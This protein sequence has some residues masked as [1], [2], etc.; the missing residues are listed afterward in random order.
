VSTQAGS[1]TVVGTGIKA[2]AH[3]TAEGMEAIRR[4]DKVLYGTADPLTKDWILRNA[5]SA[6]S[7]D[8]FYIEGGPRMVAYRQMIEEIVDHVR[9]GF[10]VCVSF[11]GHPGAFV[12]VSHESIRLLRADGYRT[13]MLP[14]VSTQDVLFCDLAFDPGQSGCQTFEATDFLLRGYQ[15]DVTSPLVLWQPS[16][17]GDF[18]FWPDTAHTKNLDVL[19][20]VLE[21]FYGRDHD[22]IAYQ[23]PLLVVTKPVITRMIIGE[24]PELVDVGLATL[25]VPSRRPSPSNG[26]GDSGPDSRGLAPPF[27]S[28]GFKTSEGPGSQKWR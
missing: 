10:K 23:A 17:I 9:G 18:R 19:A 13:R 27:D 11:E 7:L 1:L 16:C 20:E 24:L 6:A 25:Y 12:Y 8:R 3:M 28:Q 2:I 26:A 14:G 15:P 21:E 5:K 22:V 4:A